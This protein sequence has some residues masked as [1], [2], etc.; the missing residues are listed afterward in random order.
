LRLFDDFQDGFE[1]LVA[2]GIHV[3]GF[4]VRNA[5][6]IDHISRR[7][8]AQ[9]DILVGDGQRRPAVGVDDQGDV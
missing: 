1:N 7:N 6:E 9:A 8:V 4:E 3:D 5:I 2:E